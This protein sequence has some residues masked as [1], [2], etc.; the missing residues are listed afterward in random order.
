VAVLSLSDES[1]NFLF[2]TFSGIED[3]RRDVEASGKDADGGLEG[4]L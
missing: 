1:S 3:V 2:F 4:E